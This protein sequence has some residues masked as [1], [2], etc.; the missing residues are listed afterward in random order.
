ME[1][2]DR[3]VL[4]CPTEF[5]ANEV[6]MD[7]GYGDVECAAGEE[8]V[9]QERSSTQSDDG[10]QWIVMEPGDRVVIECPTE[11][12][13]DG[14]TIES[15]YGAVECA[16]GEESANTP[17]PE[18]TSTTEPAPTNTTEPGRTST[19][20]AT[21]TSGS[22]RDD[23]ESEPPGTAEATPTN[24]PE[25]GNS[26][27]EPTTTVEATPTSTAQPEPTATEP[28]GGDGSTECGEPD[29]AWHPPM[30]NG[31]AT[32]HEHGDAPPDWVTEFSQENFGHGVVYGGDEGTPNENAYK[33]EGFKGYHVTFDGVEIYFRMHMLANPMGHQGRYHSYEAYA[34]DSSG[35]VSFWQGH[36]DFGDD[37][38]ADPNVRVYGCEDVSVRPI[39]KVVV[40][41][42]CSGDVFE[43][44]YSRAGGSGLWSWDMGIN[45]EASYYHGE[46]L[47]NPS[48]PDDMS[49]WIET[50]DLGLTRRIELAWYEGRGNAP[51][52]E[53][54]CTTVNGAILDT[55]GGPQECSQGLPQYIAPT[56][57]E[58]SAP[59]N[60][61][62][63]TYPGEGVTLPN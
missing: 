39:M 34:L 17:E 4:E 62:Q 20:E 5:V 16:P 25:R 55:V 47:G 31:C 56:M 21:P 8:A 1:P 18:S 37:E 44:W 61:E 29:N 23:S 53:W 40:Q 48:D 57:T 32:G 38:G 6:T 3:L 26:D 41:N 49:T 36:L 50:G 2:G 19:P 24:G 59:G 30:V 10:S 43:D 27:P 45:I 35:N 42:G 14:S 13:A 22:G 12:I 15:G 60:A 51:E 58:V 63:K 33:H 11:F 7:P 54:F 9:S 28:A 52:G 46:S